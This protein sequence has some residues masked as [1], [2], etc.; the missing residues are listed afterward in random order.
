M[1]RV[2]KYVDFETLKKRIVFFI[3]S[4]KSVELFE[5]QLYKWIYRN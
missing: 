2:F 1:I 4:K 5:N 3:G